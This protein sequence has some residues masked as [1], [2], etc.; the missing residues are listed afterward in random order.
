MSYGE[1]EFSRGHVFVSWDGEDMSEQERRHQSVVS[2]VSLIW[3]HPVD[4]LPEGRTEH[5]FRMA[6]THALAEITSRNEVGEALM[7][8]KE[9]RE[10]MEPEFRKRDAGRRGLN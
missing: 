1:V 8:Y 7:S 2:L 10:K 9:M 4:D 5:E 3:S 6:M